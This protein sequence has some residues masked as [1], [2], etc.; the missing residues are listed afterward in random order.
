MNSSMIATEPIPDGVWD[1]D[2]LAAAAK[3]V[4]DT[5]H[6]FFYAQRTVDDRIAIGGR[7]V[8]YRYRLAHR[9]RRSGARA[10]H[11][12]PDCDAALD[13][14]AGPRRPDRARLVWSAGRAARL[15]G[16][17]RARQGDGSRMGG[18]I[19]RA[20]RHRH[21]PRR[22]HA[23][24]PGAGSAHRRSP[25]CRGSTT[26]HGTGNPN[27][28]AG[29]GCEACTSPTRPPTGTRDAAVGRPHRSQWSPTGSPAARTDPLR[30]RTGRIAGS[31]HVAL[32]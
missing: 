11:H 30:A 6:G 4:G 24:R 7:S 22:P 19:R 10:H 28:C 25:S 27:R 13:P 17:H 29:S 1:I 21:Q 8:P 3:R 5:A 2:R 16:Q 23:G 12:A 9:R 14:A 32:E 26:G 15:G 18:R 20:R 31:G